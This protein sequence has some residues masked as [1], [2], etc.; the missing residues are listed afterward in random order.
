[1]ES[2]RNERHLARSA[3]EAHALERRRGLKAGAADETDKVHEGHGGNGKLRPAC[4][5]ES[6]TNVKT[7]TVQNA[8]RGSGMVGRA[9][10]KVMAGCENTAGNK[11]VGDATK[12]KVTAPSEGGQQQR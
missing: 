11:R 2:I 9:G 3:Q 7:K 8:K 12:A 6:Y 4:K 1:M 5:M 10:T